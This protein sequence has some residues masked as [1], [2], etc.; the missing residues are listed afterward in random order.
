[1]KVI[2]Y[3]NEFVKEIEFDDS[4]KNGL[5]QEIL[6][7]YCSLMIYNIENTEIIIN[8][9]IYI[10][11][12]D[13]LPFNSI[14]KES[15]EKIDI[16]NFKIKINDRNRDINGNVIKNN[17][18]IDRYN[19]WYQNYENENYINNINNVNLSNNNMLRLPLSTLLQNILRINIRD[20]SENIQNIP[21]INQIH[22]IN[23][24]TNSNTLE[25][26]DGLLS[27][28]DES[29]NDTQDD[30]QDDGQDDSQD[31]SQDKLSSNT[32]ESFEEMQSNTQ[33]KPSNDAQDNAQTILS[34]NAQDK[35]SG[36][37]QDKLSGNTQ[38]S[39]EE[40]QS[41]AQVT[42]SSDAQVTVSSDAQVTVS[43]DAQ[44]TTSSDAQVTA[45]SDAQITVSSDA[46]IT[47]SSDAQV[48][49][50]SDAQVTASSDAPNVE[51]PTNNNENHYLSYQNQNQY[52]YNNNLTQFFFSTSD[53]NQND[54]DNL[55]NLFDNYFR[56]T[57]INFIENIFENEYND[58][59]E[60]IP[61]NL[62]EDV[63]IRLSDEQ[64][65]KLDIINY[66]D[67]NNKESQE[68]LIC[69]ENFNKDNNIVK[70]KCNHLFHT[71]CIKS[72][73][74]KESNKCPVCRIEI[75]KGNPNLD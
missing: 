1:M 38:E 34:S 73:L 31:D 12:S 52:Y 39:F 18:I 60:L 66:D 62:Q 33:N 56:N 74:C 26:L 16:D 55:I 54:M 59:P 15:L 10:L 35:L 65:D 71:D 36:I 24:T 70:L 22:Q 8:N 75:D 6:L 61:V 13:E 7:N 32:Q 63:K 46:Q 14:F 2:L 4:K 53:E 51:P 58:L 5:L 27:K 50:S 17:Y 43:S 49:V 9:K 41:N 25:E 45:S 64:F 40:I 69:L 47:V 23:I 48:T 3:Y 28:S 19:T 42:E 57:E 67:L 20:I 11:G 68:C 29:S 21:N 72:W 37:L 30:G 44:V